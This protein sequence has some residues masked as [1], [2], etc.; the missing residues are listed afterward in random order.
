MGAASVEPA[1]LIVP[2]AALELP[3]PEDD[4]PLELELEPELL[5]LLEPQATMPNDEAATAASAAMRLGFTLSPS[6]DVRQSLRPAIRGGVIQ[7]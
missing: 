7:L 6:L 5:L 3:E 1:P 2:L 4:D